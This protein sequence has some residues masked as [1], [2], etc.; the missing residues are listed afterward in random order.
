MRCF[1]MVRYGYQK[2]PL[3][4][5][6]LDFVNAYPDFITGS[7]SQIGSDIP[8]V[9]TTNRFQSFYANASYIFRGKYILSGSIRK[10]G[11]NIFGAN[12]NDRWKPLWSAGLGWALSDEKFYKLSWLPVLKLTSTFGYS[13]NVDL[14]RTA[15]PIAAYTTNTVSGLLFTRINTVNN[16]ELRWEQVSQLD[17]KL[18]FALKKEVL[19]GSVSYFVKEGSDLYGSA[20]YDYTGWGGRELLVRNVADMRGYGLD[21]ELHSKNLQ[22]GKFSWNSDLYFTFNKDKTTSYYRKSGSAAGGF[23]FAGST[24]TPIEG[25]PLYGISA[26][27]WAGLDAAGNPQGYVDGKPSANY[28]ALLNEANLTGNNVVFKGSS[29]PVVFGSL[30]NAFHFGQF[31][32]SFNLSY[33]FGYYFSRPVMSY[34]S[35][36]ATGTSNSEYAQRWQKAGD[37]LT[38]NVPSF[39][40][41]V[42]LNRDA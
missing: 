21:A 4:G 30:I 20:P 31:Y 29:N 24:I 14:S 28:T 39:T 41:P 5:T 11:S 15:L 22:S 12:S 34:N 17:L 32:L 7:T 1:D 2:D 19:S 36:V 23:L 18:S 38:T 25:M 16:P 37:E 27:K 40:L 33:R 42:N 8:L 6:S 26:Y 13:G 3:T 10:D 9:S 35:F